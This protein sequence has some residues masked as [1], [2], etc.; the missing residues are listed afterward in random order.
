MILWKQKL[1]FVKGLY[2]AGMWSFPGPMVE[3]SIESGKNAAELV[4]R[5]L[6]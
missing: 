2:H 6:R 1:K 5:F 4:M 3:P